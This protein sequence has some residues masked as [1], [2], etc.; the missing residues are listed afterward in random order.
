[1]TAPIPSPLVDAVAK[2]Q[3]VLFAGAGI[4]F[5]SL[6]IAGAGLRDAIGAEI[7]KDYKGYDPGQRSFEDVCDE[8]A[9]INDLSGLVNKIAEYIPQNA[10]PTPAH[11]AAVAM[12]RF[13]VTTNWDV[14]FEEAYRQIGQGKQTI[15]DETDAL[16][17]NADQ[18]NLIK[19]HGTVDRPLTIV[20]TTDDYESYADTHPRLFDVLANLL[21]TNTVLFVG[22]GLRDEHVRR[23]LSRIRRQRGAWSRKASAI[24]FYD[25]VRTKLL[26]ARK[27]EVI[28]G[29]A[30]DVLPE[31]AARAAGGT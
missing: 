21:D 11:C 12:F 20:A 22:Y 18:H 14:L 13:I 30:D 19:L 16:N 9:A 3:A 26:A 23:L 27:I 31:L 4:S 24:G 10:S 28:P 25:E 29:A 17:F 1:M 6:G 2:R 15:A 8:Y 7:A 5:A